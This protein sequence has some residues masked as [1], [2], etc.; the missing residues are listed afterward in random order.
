[1]IIK[2]EFKYKYKIITKYKYKIITK[3]KNDENRKWW[4]I[5]YDI[6]NNVFR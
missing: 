4:A 6:R 1:M 2:I 3:Y 5:G